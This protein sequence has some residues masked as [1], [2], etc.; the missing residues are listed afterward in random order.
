[1]KS[2]GVRN[3]FGISV[4]MQSESLNKSS[5]ESYPVTGRL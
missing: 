2:R 5:K 3:F 1:M 4:H